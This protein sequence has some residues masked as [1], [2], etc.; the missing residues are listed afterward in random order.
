MTL[1][2]RRATRAELTPAAVN[3]M[4]TNVIF[5]GRTPLQAVLSGG[6]PSMLEVRSLLDG[7]R[8][9]P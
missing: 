1:P 4:V 2:G 3:A 6:I 5:A 8:G 9:G 7:R